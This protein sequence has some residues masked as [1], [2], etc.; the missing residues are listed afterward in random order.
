MTSR[1][2]DLFEILGSSKFSFQ[3][4]YLILSGFRTPQTP[5][6][7]GRTVINN[8]V[9]GFLI[10]PEKYVV[11]RRSPGWI[12][13]IALLF[14]LIRPFIWATILYSIIFGP[15]GMSRRCL[16]RIYYCL[17]L[18]ITFISCYSLLT[19]LFCNFQSYYKSVNI[20]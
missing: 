11:P 6:E 14:A 10:F 16:F 13:V 5:F 12:D 1:Y 3:C 18:V 7:I 19:T 15:Y 17:R 4:F 8:M 20:S 2:F 9:E